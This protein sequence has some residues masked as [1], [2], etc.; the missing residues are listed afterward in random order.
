MAAQDRI[1]E[2]TSSGQ[3]TIASNN[4]EGRGPK[5]IRTAPVSRR[6]LDASSFVNLVGGNDCVSPNITRQRLCLQRP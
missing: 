6:E 5:F 3:L 1:D 2:S 4:F